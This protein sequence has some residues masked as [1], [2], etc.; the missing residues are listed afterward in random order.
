MK[1]VFSG[2]PF[3]RRAAIVTQAPLFDVVLKDGEAVNSRVGGFAGMAPMARLPATCLTNF[4]HWVLMNISGNFR[5]SFLIL[6]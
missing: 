3:Q 2:I 5:F 1:A 6:R 4:F